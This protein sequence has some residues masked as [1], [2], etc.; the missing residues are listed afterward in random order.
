[1]VPPY[2]LPLIGGL[3]LFILASLPARAT[4]LICKQDCVKGS[5]AQATC[6]RVKAGQPDGFCNCV[7]ASETLDGS[8]YSSWCSAWGQ[9]QPACA[10]QE[11]ARDAEGNPLPETSVQLENSQELAQALG[12]R[13]PY[14]AALVRALEDLS[15]WADGPVA[16]FVHDSYYD[17]SQ[18]SLTHTAALSFAGSVVMNGLGAAQIDITVGGDMTGLSHLKSYSDVAT[19]SAIPP[20]HVQG[21]VTD[22]GLH[23]S[24]QVA[25]AD[26]RSETLQW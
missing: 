20:Q 18:G 3:F 1:M 25:A 6:E 16:G 17:E 5:C 22:G 9:P 14:V 8:T 2:L 7:S 19:P 26:G 13:N 23:G 24:L 15:N 10:S 11:P 4:G 21:T 12:S